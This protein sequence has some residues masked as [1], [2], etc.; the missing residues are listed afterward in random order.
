MRWESAF[1]V[2]SFYWDTMRISFHQEEHSQSFEVVLSSN[3]DPN[4]MLYTICDIE[5]AFGEW[6]RTWARLYKE[7]EKDGRYLE[8]VRRQLLK[9]LEKEMRGTDIDYAVEVGPETSKIQVR[10]FYG[11]HIVL[12]VVNYDFERTLK[13]VGFMLSHTLLGLSSMSPEPQ[14]TVGADHI[15]GV[16]IQS[17]PR[18][19]LEQSPY[20]DVTQYITELT[21]AV[22]HHEEDLR[23]L[24]PLA[25]SVLGQVQLIKFALALRGQDY[26]QLCDESL[27]DG[28]SAFFPMRI[29]RDETGKR[30]VLS[31][32][33][34]ACSCFLCV[35][36]IDIEVPEEVIYEEWF[37]SETLTILSVAQVEDKTQVIVEF[38]AD[39]SVDS[40][41]ISYQGASIEQAIMA[42]KDFTSLC[43]VIADGVFR[44]LAS[45]KTDLLEVEE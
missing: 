14:M 39:A 29:I 5:H 22:L 31:Y 41:P 26:R 4:E 17:L 40:I 36:G 28:V 11:Q 13:N 42:E 20:I 35:F 45:P 25:N 1:F 21:D 9:S 30:D 38:A 12:E 43:D 19:S 34:L 27:V 3:I 2:L 18:V 23:R 37:E 15:S 16:D 7:C 44:L 33:P 8:E 10:T 32:Y 24:L 6:E